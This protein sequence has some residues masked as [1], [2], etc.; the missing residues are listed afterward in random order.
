MAEGGPRLT[1]EVVEVE[2]D[3][4]VLFAGGARLTSLHVQN[5]SVKW[6]TELEPPRELDAVNLRIDESAV[7][8]SHLHKAVA[9]NLRTGQKLWQFK[10]T[11]D[12]YYKRFFS[13]GFYG[14]GPDYF[15]GSGDGGWIFA[16]EKESGELIYERQYEYGAHGLSYEGGSLYFTQAWTPEG[17]EG[18]SKGGIMKVDAATGDSLWNFRTPRG[19]FYRMRPFVE[20]GVVYAG[21]D[22]GENTVFVAL[23]AAT[24][25]VIWRNTR[26]RVYAAE[27]ADGKIFVNDGSD[28]LALDKD[29]GSTLWRAR[30]DAGHGESGLAYLDGYVYHPHGQAMRVVNAET[31][32]VVHV[33][34]PPDGS[35]FWEVGAGAGKVFAQSSG[36]L[37]AYEPYQ[38]E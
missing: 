18:Q 35:Y 38:P 21:T 8:G 9:W 16:I 22:G 37:V 11:V 20:D 4:L 33:E 24:G 14:L 30:L 2:E 29:D 6:S 34:A 5:G 12:K 31:G 3:T 32:D 36:Y 1:P 17:A 26:A 27:M 13:L 7:Y 25:E 15:Y 19:G 10:S 23:D 28:L